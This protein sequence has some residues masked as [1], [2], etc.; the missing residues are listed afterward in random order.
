MIAP[1]CPEPGESRSYQEKRGEKG[2]DAESK[3]PKI[4]EGLSPAPSEENGSSRNEVREIAEVQRERLFQAK[5]LRLK[6]KDASERP[7]CYNSG[8]NEPAKG[9]IHGSVASNLL[10]EGGNTKRQRN[11][12]EKSEKMSQ[13]ERL[14]LIPVHNCGATG[15][16]PNT[17]TE[18]P[19]ENAACTGLLSPTSKPA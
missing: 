15:L 2:P 10:G 18:T 12:D 16:I 1:E 19:G 8:R 3:G 7:D 14:K 6:P 5:E 17:F 9:T 4:K 13:R 11:T